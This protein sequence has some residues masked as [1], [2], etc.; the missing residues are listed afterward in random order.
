MTA[1]LVCS[2]S[3]S[4]R[5][6]FGTLFLRLDLGMLDG[7]PPPVPTV[8]GKFYPSPLLMVYPTKQPK[9]RSFSQRDF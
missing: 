8:C 1:D 9:E 6:R 5:T 4:A 2:R 3:G 7:L